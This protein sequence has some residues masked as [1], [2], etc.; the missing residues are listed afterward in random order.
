MNSCFRV[1]G[2]KVAERWKGLTP[3]FPTINMQRRPVLHCP[4][5]S[6][7]VVTRGQC[8]SFRFMVGW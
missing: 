3:R 5:G 6:R 8:I 2:R 1:I 7:F 4:G